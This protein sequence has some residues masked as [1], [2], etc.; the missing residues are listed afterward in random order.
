[1]KGAAM[2]THQIFTL[3]F[4]IVSIVFA[5]N[6]SAW[7]ADSVSPVIQLDKPVIMKNEVQTVYALIDFDVIS[8]L[9]EKNEKRPDL[10]IGLVI[11]RSGSMQSKGKLT[12]AKSAAKTLVDQLLPSDQISIVEYDDRISVVWPLAPIKNP[13]KIKQTVD[14][15]TPGGSTNLAG[16]LKKGID[17]L[18]AGESQAIRRVILMSD[19]LANTGITDPDHIALMAKN[20]S[21]R[22]VNITTMGLGLDYN[23]DLMQVIAENGGGKYYYIENPDQMARIYSEEMSILFSMVT[24]NMA[25][26]LETGKAV[27][28]LKVFGYPVETVNSKNIIKL[29][30]FYAGEKRSLLVQ[31]ELNKIDR[32]KTEIATLRLKYHDLADKKEKKITKKIVVQSTKDANK[33]AENENRSVAIEAILI[34]A[35]QKHEE[36]VRLYE[37]GKKKE[38]KEALAALCSRLKDHNKGYNDVKIKKKIDALE[39]EEQEIERAEKNRQYRQNYLKKSKQA[40]YRSKKGKRGKYLL[41]E[42]AQGLE[43]ENLQMALRKEGVYNGPINGRFSLEVRAAV[44]QF[45]AKEGLAVDGVA[46]PRTLRALGLY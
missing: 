36:S 17:Q 19:G 39:M 43:V 31:F 8:S 12:Y 10:N 35:D 15:L 20:A 21:D 4:S 32:E 41:Q 28:Q 18:F 38:A 46:G 25:M 44:E 13:D 16:G 7:A 2:K 40:F 26:A 37:K 42:G 22:S 23:E 3:L 11:D 27:K 30:N 14:Q 45:Q 24:K 33:V 5:L 34:A 9:A 6:S 29:N 1:M